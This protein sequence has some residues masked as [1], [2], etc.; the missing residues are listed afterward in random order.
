M[1]NRTLQQWFQLLADVANMM[2]LTGTNWQPP[3]HRGELEMI[4]VVCDEMQ[5]PS[6]VFAAHAGLAGV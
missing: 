5:V 3:V 1:P 2:R 4:R 6:E